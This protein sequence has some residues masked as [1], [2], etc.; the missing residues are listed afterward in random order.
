MTEF[1]NERQAH[2]A[3]ANQAGRR[4]RF[5]RPRPLSIW[6]AIERPAF[7]V[8]AL[9]LCVGAWYGVWLFIKELA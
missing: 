9:A 3:L 6:R 2:A 4:P 5:L 7:W 8:L 1:R